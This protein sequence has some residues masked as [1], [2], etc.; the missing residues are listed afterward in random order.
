MSITA[1]S[2]FV[3]AVIMPEEPIFY[4]CVIINV[5]QYLPFRLV[6]WICCLS[7]QMTTKRCLD[8]HTTHISVERSSLLNSTPPLVIVIIPCYKEPVPVIERTL[9]SILESE[10]ALSNIRIYISFDGL[11][12]AHIYEALKES[13]QAASKPVPGTITSHVTIKGA[14]VTLCLFEHRGKSGCQ[15][16]TV[17]HIKHHH[18]EDFQSPLNSY[19][20]FLDSDTTIPPHTFSSFANRM[21]SALNIMH[22]SC[23]TMTDARSITRVSLQQS[24][25]RYHHF[26]EYAM[27]P[28]YFW[29]QYRKWNI[30][31]MASIRKL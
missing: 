17:E 16:E 30:Y 3:T 26:K 10:Y 23:P 20:L 4:S 21:V 28:R 2:A 8:A 7:R 19:I 29:V 15:Q 18:S 12:N 24:W 9:N 25:L 5:I 11:E 13:I 6:C 1:A 14:E 27:P 22:L 31:S